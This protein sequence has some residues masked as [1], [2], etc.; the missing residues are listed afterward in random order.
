MIKIVAKSQVKPEYKD[1]YIRLAKKLVAAS[2]AEEGNIFYDLHQAQE[3]PYVLTMIEGWQDQESIEKHN[4]S[5]SF[6]TIV[7]ELGKMRISSDVTH[8]TVI[9]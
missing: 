6:R 2:K 8:Y 9:E 4:G 1:E 3:D 5:E 7:P